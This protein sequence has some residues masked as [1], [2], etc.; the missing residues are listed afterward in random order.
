MLS[1]LSVFSERIDDSH[2]VLK[3]HTKLSVFKWPGCSSSTW[4][5]AKRTAHSLLLG[6]GSQDI[7]T[8]ALANSSVNNFENPPVNVCVLKSINKCI[9]FETHQQMYTFSKPSVDL[10]VF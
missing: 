5:T 9:R 8:Y 1:S 10:Y 2:A 7:Q 3:M 4:H 6:H